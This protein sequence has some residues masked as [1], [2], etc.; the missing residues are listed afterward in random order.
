MY[1]NTKYF[2][3]CRAL[4]NDNLPPADWVG[5][6]NASY[7]LGPTFSTPGLRVKMIVH[8]QNEMSYAYNVIATLRG[9]EEPGN[10][11]V[12]TIMGFKI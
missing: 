12:V 2:V 9:E 11:I 3:W 1:F 5:G 4:N 6:L 10:N 8:T 7:S